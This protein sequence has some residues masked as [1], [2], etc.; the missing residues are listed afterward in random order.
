V[1]DGIMK[2][3]LRSG[4][5]P[6]NLEAPPAS[7]RKGQEPFLSRPLEAARDLGLKFVTPLRMGS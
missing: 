5:N 2:A 7:A 3:L 6:E 1:Q 4:N